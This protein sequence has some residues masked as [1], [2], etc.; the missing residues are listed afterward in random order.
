M[1][2]IVNANSAVNVAQQF[3][4]R[5]YGYEGA[6]SSAVGENAETS[7]YD[8][9]FAQAARPRG[10]APMEPPICPELLGSTSKTHADDFIS[11]DFLN[12]LVRANAGMDSREEATIPQTP[13]SPPHQNTFIVRSEMHNDH[14]C[15]TAPPTRQIEVGPLPGVRSTLRNRQ[16]IPECSTHVCKWADCNQSFGDVM[17]LRFHVTETHVRRGSLV[18]LKCAWNYCGKVY[19]KRDNITSHL[20]T[21][22]PY[23]EHDCDYC[24]RKWQRRHDLT[25]HIKQSHAPVVLG[26]HRYWPVKRF[27]GLYSDRSIAVTEMGSF[28]QPAPLDV[29]PE[30]KLHYIKIEEEPLPRNLGPFI[31]SNLSNQICSAPQNVTNQPAEQGRPAFAAAFRYSQVTQN[32]NASEVT[33]DKGLATFEPNS[34]PANTDPSVYSLGAESQNIAEQSQISSLNRPVE[35]QPSVM[36]SSSS[37]KNS[38]HF[39]GPTHVPR[40]SKR[41]TPPHDTD[42]T[43]KRHQS[44]V[45]SFP[46]QRRDRPIDKSLMPLAP[47]PLLAAPPFKHVAHLE[48]PGGQTTPQTAAGANPESGYKVF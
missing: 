20:H 23:F 12:A 11:A 16:S 29:L 37:S 45:L 26:S 42:P 33:A 15:T 17:L 6:L 10:S 4:P 48:P 34:N 31:A 46:T 28:Q 36:K 9:R 3:N 25:K 41:K 40:R 13:I 38:A 5:L 18:T 1:E 39:T 21:H 44:G 35:N 27:V 43:P 32:Q 7:A 22:I 14:L 47:L 19:K 8:E 24:G 2:P 30:G